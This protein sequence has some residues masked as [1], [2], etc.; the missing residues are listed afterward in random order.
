MHCVIAEIDCNALDGLPSRTHTQPRTLQDQ[1]IQKD[2]SFV[3]PRPMPFG[4]VV[5]ALRAVPEIYDVALVDVY[6]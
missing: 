2:I 3:L 1:I 6:A 5:D 4:T